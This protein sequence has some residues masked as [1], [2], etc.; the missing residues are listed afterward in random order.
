VGWGT[1]VAVAL[2]GLLAV[3]LLAR[4]GRVHREVEAITASVTR[5]ARLRGALDTLRAEAV[6]IRRS[7]DATADVFA[8]R[9]HR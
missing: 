2:L 4:A 3:V 1:I 5:L 9:G 6:A 7:T 8:H